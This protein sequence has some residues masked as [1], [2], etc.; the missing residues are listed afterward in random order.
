[1]RKTWGVL[2]VA[3]CLLLGGVLSVM[4]PSLIS[5][6]YS[7]PDEVSAN[8]TD[9]FPG[10][11]NVFR[12]FHE[13]VGIFVLREERPFDVN[14]FFTG[15]VVLN[16]NSG[17]DELGR[18]FVN[19]MEIEWQFSA[20]VMDTG[21]EWQ[22][23]DIIRLHVHFGRTSVSYWLP[24]AAVAG[25]YGI[26]ATAYVDGVPLIDNQ[27]RLVTGV[28][29]VKYAEDLVYM[30]CVDL[31]G[32]TYHNVFAEGNGLGRTI[33]IR[34]MVNP[35]AV[36]VEDIEPHQLHEVITAGGDRFRIGN[37]QDAGV[38]LQGDLHVRVEHAWGGEF[39][40]W[41]IVPEYEWGANGILLIHLPWNLPFGNYVIRVYSNITDTVFGTFVIQNG[42]V[43]VEP[44]S[45]LGAIV[46]PL[47]IMGLILGGIFFI[48]FAVPAVAVSV[49]NAKYQATE[50][51]RYRDSIMSN[52]D[53]TDE[54]KEEMERQQTAAKES[55][56]GKFLGKM[57]ENRQKRE[58]AR[59]AGLTMDEFNE[60]EKRLKKDENMKKVSL[61]TFRQ[62]LDD[63]D[64][65]VT[66]QQLNEAEAA[67]KASG[68]EEKRA[69]GAPEFNMLE[70]M[71]GNEEIE[72][73]VAERTKVESDDAA[74][75]SKKDS[76][77]SILG[78]LDE[79]EAVDSGIAQKSN[80]P[81]TATTI[82][83][84]KVDTDT[85]K[86]SSILGRLSALTTGESIAED[87]PV[88]ADVPKVDAPDS[89]KMVEEAKPVVEE[90][91]VDSGND[92]EKD[93]SEDSDSGGSSILSRLKGLTGG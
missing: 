76:K 3:F 81:S 66:Q 51:K 68:K 32:N 9:H 29:V 34:V 83:E 84:P 87:K 22:P 36:R 55:R 53:L 80:E 23:T 27:D 49:Q 74:V 8:T 52:N 43:F 15:S 79:I 38:G 65:I 41:N 77:R 62:A 21:G 48:M 57:A 40:W 93:S 82:Q 31:F 70:S 6:R 20:Y 60:L 47:L 10:I 50:R 46:V 7:V 37:L 59:E 58:I 75:S 14:D 13:N 64:N 12:L 33:A 2:V 72:E 73:A 92:G 19:F 89:T 63:R 67:S 39:G 86:S 88:E 71:K 56:S 35:G 18:P 24:R 61:A 11:T 45:G 44:G 5:D 1:M 17:H 16:V 69:K 25:T 30:Y 85:P 54:E 78:K 90:V 28:Y 42:G 91:K 4:S 26:R